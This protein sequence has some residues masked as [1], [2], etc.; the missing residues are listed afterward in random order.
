MKPFKIFTAMLI[1]ALTVSFSS[2][3][4]DVKKKAQEAE[5]TYSVS[6]D[7][8]NCKK[9]LDAMLPYIKGVKDLKVDLDTRTVWFKYLPEKVT[10]E[11]LKEEIEK[12][13]FTAEEIVPAAGKK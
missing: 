2:V 9:R 7:C 8:V 10:K 6:I 1:A 11:Q 5:V 3:A 12:Q 13:G 4:Q